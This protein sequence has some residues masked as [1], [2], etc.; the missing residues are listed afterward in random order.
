MKL[1]LNSILKTNENLLKYALNAICFYIVFIWMLT[2]TRYHNG[3][4][5]LILKI[6]NYDISVKP[7]YFS[8]GYPV[9]QFLVFFIL[10]A[11]EN[12]E[13]I[14]NVRLLFCLILIKLG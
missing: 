8:M 1:A 7:T 12:I 9:Q 4:T 2:K 5:P 11:K 3:I 6:T 13:N 10:Q 14:E